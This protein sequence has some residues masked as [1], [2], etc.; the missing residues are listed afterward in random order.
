MENDGREAPAQFGA[1]AA[2]PRG[3]I[4]PSARRRGRGDPQP[5]PAPVPSGQVRE[6]TFGRLFMNS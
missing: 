4:A 1:R 6:T 5:I 3:Q 2:L